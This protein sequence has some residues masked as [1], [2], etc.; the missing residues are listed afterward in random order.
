MN[1]EYA[2]FGFFGVLD[3]DNRDRNTKFNGIDEDL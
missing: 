2:N 1:V 3:E